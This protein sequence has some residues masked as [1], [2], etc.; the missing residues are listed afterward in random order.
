MA[1]FRPPL[2][3]RAGLGSDAS[4]CRVA[5]VCSAAGPPPGRRASRLSAGAEEEAA[6][7]PACAAGALEFAERA[8]APCAPLGA[9]RRADAF[10]E[11][12]PGV[13]FAKLSPPTACAGDETDPLCGIALWAM[14]SCARSPAGREADSEAPFTATC[15]FA[16]VEDDA[17]SCARRCPTPSPS[18]ACCVGERCEARRPPRA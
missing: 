8:S 11:R 12:S 7:R 10:G 18:D 5:R 6:L 17:A 14:T 9:D 4:P 16:C 13:R 2:A 1:F 15:R 3:A